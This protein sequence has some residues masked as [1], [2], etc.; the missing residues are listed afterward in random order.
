MAHA[1][2]LFHPQISITAE[3]VA[4]KLHLSI[5]QA[6][7]LLSRPGTHPTL[8]KA[9]A[10]AFQASIFHTLVEMAAVPHEPVPVR[11]D[12][13]IALAGLVVGRAHIERT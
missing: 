6:D 5:E 10:D 11:V 3:G 2:L 7:Q 1:E 8:E 4:E 12:S 9:L 13:A